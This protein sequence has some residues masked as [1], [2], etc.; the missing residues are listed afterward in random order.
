MNPYERRIIHTAVQ[1]IEGAKSWSEGEELARHV[2]IGPVEGRRAPRAE[3]GGR[4]WW[5]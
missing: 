2:V 4:R 5:Q 1:D 3:D